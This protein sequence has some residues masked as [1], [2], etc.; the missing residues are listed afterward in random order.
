MLNNN[1]NNIN[2]QY[3][4]FIN[5]ATLLIFIFSLRNINYIQKK[6]IKIIIII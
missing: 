2:V 5:K 4:M 3:I 1:Y 6:H